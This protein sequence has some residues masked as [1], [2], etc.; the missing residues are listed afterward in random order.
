MSRVGWVV[1]VALPFSAELSTAI[2]SASI[3]HALI[4]RSRINSCFILVFDFAH[5]LLFVQFC[6]VRPFT[7]AGP[8]LAKQIQTKQ[9]S[10]IEING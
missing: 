7:R 2:S 6:G 10:A 4:R 8:S 3:V 9:N 5:F 1:F